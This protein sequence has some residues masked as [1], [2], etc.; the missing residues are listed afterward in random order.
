MTDPVER[1]ARRTL[2]LAERVNGVLQEHGIQAAVIGAMA[3]AAHNYPR[4]TRDID[5]ATDTDPFTKLREVADALRAQGLRAE[6]REPDPQDPLGGVLDV[7]QK[8]CRRV[9]VVNFFN[10]LAGPTT[11]LGGEAVRNAQDGLLPGVRLRVVDLPYLVALKLYAGGPR[12]TNDVIELLARNPT[13]LSAIR[14]VCARHALAAE[15]EKL[16]GEIGMED[17]PGDRS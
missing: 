14:D 9:H 6:L 16:L 10:P 8:G 7:R 11:G 17:R 15:L 2:A 13:R 3:A 5:L 1:M 4:D 12:N